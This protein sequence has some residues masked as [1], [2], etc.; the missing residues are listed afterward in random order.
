MVPCVTLSFKTEHAFLTSMFY[1]ER[2]GIPIT[3]REFA[4]YDKYEIFD[5]S[6]MY[7]N[8]KI[9]SLDYSNLITK[10]EKVG[11]SFLSARD[12]L[13]YDRKYKSF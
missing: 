12:L 10:Y 2:W 9:Y 4:I 5:N 11:V 13:K 6:K 3:Q 8:K 7:Y 1:M